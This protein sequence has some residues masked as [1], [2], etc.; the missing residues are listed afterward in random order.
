VPLAHQSSKPIRSPATITH[1][2]AAVADREPVDGRPAPEKGSPIS[3][4]KVF[5]AT[6]ARDREDL[7]ERVTAW[8]AAN[9]QLE[10]R[11]TF[12]RL[13]SDKA[14]HCL[15]LVLACAGRSPR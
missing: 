5:S 15:S 9:P 1:R 12:V 6:K 8:L 3:A 4:F 11:E 2:E 13:S 7:G 10:V 14:F